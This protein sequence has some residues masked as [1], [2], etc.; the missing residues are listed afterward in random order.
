MIGELLRALAIVK[1]LIVQRKE[2]VQQWE[3]EMVY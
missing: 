3:T 1:N 2:G